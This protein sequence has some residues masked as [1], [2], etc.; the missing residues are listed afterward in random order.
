MIVILVQS[1]IICY[2]PKNEVMSYV[3]YF[4]TNII[5]CS[6]TLAFTFHTNNFINVFHIFVVIVIVVVICIQIIIIII[7]LIVFF[8]NEFKRH[9]I[10]VVV[11]VIVIKICFIFVIQICFRKSIIIGIISISFVNVMAMVLFQGR[12]NPYQRFVFIRTSRDKQIFDDFPCP[13]NLSQS[14][15]SQYT[16]HVTIKQKVFGN[17]F[18][19][20]LQQP[21]GAHTC[22]FCLSGNLS[23]QFEMSST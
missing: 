21:F 9:F 17:V 8:F 16:F 2:I 7:I 13:M 6:S 19:H 5:T 10:V 15:N 3:C 12:N 1:I 14:T 4:V 11:V 23:K 20:N 18:D 22:V